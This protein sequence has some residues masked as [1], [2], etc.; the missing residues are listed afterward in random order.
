MRIL[1][2][3][4]LFI[5]LRLGCSSSRVNIDRLQIRQGKYYL[6]NS[7]KLYNGK[8]VFKHD[9]GNVSNIIEIKEGVPDGKWIAYGYKKEI[10]Q[11]VLNV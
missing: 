6:I 8:V 5:F 4:S 9:N 10:V 11:E 3:S 2:L 7:S 1:L